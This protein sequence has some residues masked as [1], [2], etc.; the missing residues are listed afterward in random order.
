MASAPPPVLQFAPFSSAVDAT[1]WHALADR[2][3]SVFRLSTDPVPIGG[4]YF[5]GNSSLG[6]GGSAFDA[7]E[8]SPRATVP[9]NGLLRNAN[10]I[11]AFKD[12]DKPALLSAAAAKIWAAIKNGEALE[13]QSILASFVLL[14]FADL[15]KYK[16][17][18]WFAFP[19]LLPSTHFTTDP[20]FPIRPLKSLWNSQKIDAL[21]AAYDS[22]RGLSLA[23]SSSPPENSTTTT[24][25]RIP[26]DTNFVLV[27][28]DPSNSNSVILGKLS[29]WDLFWKDIPAE[30][31]TVA[32]A[33]PSNLPTNPGWP[34]RNFLLLLKYR[35]KLGSINIICYRESQGKRDTSGTGSLFVKV[36]MPG[37]LEV[38]E[39]PKS[40]GWEK[41]SSGKLGARLVDLAPMMDP[42]RLAS[43]AVDLNLKLMRWRIMPQLQ[44][45]KISETKCLLLGAG[46]LGCYVA[47]ALMAWGVRNITL[48]DNGT[49]SFSNPVRQP[50][51]SF[52]DS[53]A[54]KPKAAAAAENLKKIFP[55]INAEGVALSIPMPGHPSTSAEQTERDVKQLQELVD[56]HDAIFLLTDSRE[57]RWLPTVMGAVSQKVVINCA[58]GF[59]TFLVMRHGAR[60]AGAPVD[61]DVVHGGKM[62]CY[63]CNDVVAP[64]DSL[65]DRTLDQ[66][67][68]VTRPGLS[69]LAS[70]LSVELMV[71]LLNHPDGIWAPAE[72]SNGPTEPTTHPLGIVPHQIR[73]FLTHFSN[74]LVSGSAYDKCTACSEK[75]LDTYKRD[76]HL[77]VD[78]VL[79][80]PKFLEELTGLTQL[81]NETENA[82]VDWDEE[83]DIE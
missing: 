26:L 39:T 16:F 74:L 21:K 48:V 46:T 79:K 52:D 44:L 27:K 61:D 24:A 25:P 38:D 35:F 76:G 13:D 36:N 12:E 37:T 19:A 69:Q 73:G 83:D 14:T 62:G 4:F 57:A 72:V 78:K 56:G 3:M 45:E 65:S 77:F 58:L 29:E 81:H 23:T 68:T 28:S 67:C 51:Y 17:Y 40:V 34:L 11:E 53:V 15:K 80:D 41:N 71:S 66:Q 5:G 7:A 10:T 75:V 32:F 31:W 8:F 54:G 6:V 59:D 18:Y 42:T 43:T 9:A 30:D 1:F 64:A 55:G 2:K 63:Y 82:D 33:D 70:G 50:L 20:Y 22:L 60:G 47:R 49:V